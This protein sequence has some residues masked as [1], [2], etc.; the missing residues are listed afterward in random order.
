MYTYM[1]FYSPSILK[2]ITDR[3]KKNKQVHIQ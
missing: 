1:N 3:Q 2:A